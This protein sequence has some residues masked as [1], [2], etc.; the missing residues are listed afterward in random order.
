MRT[1][2]RVLVAGA[3]GV[4]LSVCLWRVFFPDP[5][6]DPLCEPSMQAFPAGFPDH[7]QINFRDAKGGQGQVQLNNDVSCY[8]LRIVRADGSVA[9][10]PDGIWGPLEIGTVDLYPDG[11]QAVLVVSSSGGSGSHTTVLDLVDPR[12]RAIVELRLTQSY[13][14]ADPLTE[15]GTSD[16]YGDARFRLERACLER[17]KYRYGY[18]DDQMVQRDAGNMEY[19]EYLWARHNGP[20]NDG[21]MAVRRYPGRHPDGG[22]PWLRVEHCGLVFTVFFRGGVWAYDPLKNESFV[23]FHARDFYNSPTDLAASGQWLLI[24]AGYE[25]LVLVQICDWRLRRLPVS[26]SQIDTFEVGGG[27]A[28]VNGHITIDLITGKTRDALADPDL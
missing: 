10:L 19:A 16:N 2:R 8:R 26:A 24:N 1:R 11:R 15:V 13:D 28:V 23:V 9:D 6:P 21:K 5:A 4:I 20:V 27:K 12:A 7:H 18:L 3:A 14:R 17:L 22:F 25:G